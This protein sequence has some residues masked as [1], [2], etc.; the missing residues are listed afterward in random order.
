MLVMSLQGVKAR[1]PQQDGSE[2]PGNSVWAHPVETSHAHVPAQDYGPVVLYCHPRGRC[3]DDR[4]L[5]AAAH[6][7]TRRPVRDGSN[8]HYWLLNAWGLSP[9]TVFRICSATSSGEGSGGPGPP[10]GI[11]ICPIAIGQ[12]IK[13]LA[14]VCHSVSLLVWL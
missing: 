13:S 9:T 14:S 7:V 10:V 5:P 2:E 1:E 11:F 4:S 6:E 3:T 8:F 12:I